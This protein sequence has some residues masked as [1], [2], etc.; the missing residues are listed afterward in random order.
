MMGEEDPRKE[1]ETETNPDGVI[2]LDDPS[3]DSYDDSDYDD[4]LEE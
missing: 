3:D 1:D 2:D 4:D